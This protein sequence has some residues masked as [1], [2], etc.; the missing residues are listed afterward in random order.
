MFFAEHEKDGVRERGKIKKAENCTFLMSDRYQEEELK[1]FLRCLIEEVRKKTKDEGFKTKLYFEK[2]IQFQI[3]WFSPI[4]EQVEF[5]QQYILLTR[6]ENITDKEITIVRVDYKNALTRINEWVES[7]VWNIQLPGIYE[8]ATYKKIVQ[9]WASDIYDMERNRIFNALGMDINKQKP[10]TMGWLPYG[11]ASWIFIEGILPLDMDAIFKRIKDDDKEE[12]MGISSRK[13]SVDIK[14]ETKLRENEKQAFGAYIY[15]FTWI[16]E[17]PFNEWKDR[18]TTVP[19]MLIMNDIV[20]SFTFMGKKFHILKDGFILLVCDNE[21]ESLYLL[22]SLMG[23]FDFLD[24]IVEAIK[25]EDIGRSVLNIKTQRLKEWARSGGSKRSWMVGKHFIG[26]NDFKN[27][28]RILDPDRLKEV[29]EKAVNIP[30]SMSRYFE[31][32]VEFKTLHYEKSYNSSF[33]IGW[34]LVEGLLKNIWSNHLDI[35]WKK[36]INSND[37]KEMKEGQNWTISILIRTLQLLSLLTNDLVYELNVLRK[38]RNNL[39]HRI[40]KRRIDI[41]REENINLEKVCKVLIQKIIEIEK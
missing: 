22:N 20:H 2:P 41:S 35:N 32:F 10:F 27:N 39:T 6:L 36:I 1:E 15:P 14:H 9:K 40:S 28:F 21:E 7:E 24:F 31:I 8:G 23:I 4:K 38:K 33:L 17:I 13:V 26:Y 19:I 3:L 12:K 5:D 11:D 34:A 25:F 37:R 16:G 30:K 18:M 29:T